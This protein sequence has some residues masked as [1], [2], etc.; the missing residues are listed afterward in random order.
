MAER[1]VLQEEAWL[2]FPPSNLLEHVMVPSAAVGLRH[3]LSMGLQLL[4]LLLTTKG[5]DL[6]SVVASFYS[7]TPQDSMFEAALTSPLCFVTL[8]QYTV[9]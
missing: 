2:C 7:L 9:S 6:M 3:T 5:L 4:L 1:Q 8:R